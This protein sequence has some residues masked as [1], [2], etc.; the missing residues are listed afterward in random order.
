MANSYC[1]DEYCETTR[2]EDTQESSDKKIVIGLY[3]LFLIA[4]T[5]IVWYGASIGVYID[6]AVLN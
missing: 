4:S 1:H 5:A 3:I 6:P 2:R